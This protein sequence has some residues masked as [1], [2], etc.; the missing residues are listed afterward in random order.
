[1]GRTYTQLSCGCLI[2]CDGGG[3]LI[4]GC[5]EGK[6]CKVIEYMNEHIMFMGECKVCNP[7]AFNETVLKYGTKKEIKKYLGD[8]K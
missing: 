3:G 6:D 5:D 4:P 7:I 8:K 1:M 2:S